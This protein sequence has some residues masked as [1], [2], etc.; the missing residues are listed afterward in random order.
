LVNEFQH[1]RNVAH[2][3][4]NTLRLAPGNLIDC[5]VASTLATIVPVA[6][7]RHHPLNES[8]VGS[9]AKNSSGTMLG[10]LSGLKNH[11][12]FYD[13][14]M[15]DVFCFLGYNHRY[16]IQLIPEETDSQ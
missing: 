1:G 7:S 4:G 9:L 6:A 5:S 10:G 3:L 14:N 13:E 11:A 8:E 2:S 15:Q 12:G 16:Y